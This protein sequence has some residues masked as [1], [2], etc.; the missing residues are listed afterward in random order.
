MTDQARQQAVDKQLTRQGLV[1][2]NADVLSAM[3]HSGEGF[4]F[5]PLRVKTSGEITGEAL[6]SAE[7]LGKLERHTR[8]ILES[9]AQELAAGKIAADPFWEGEDRNAC[10]WCEY[11]A[12]C[13]FREGSGDDHRRWLSGVKAEEFWSRLDSFD[14]QGRV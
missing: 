1:L 14:R 10:K 5:L 8:Q 6:V 12:A 7:R 11:A 13:Q 4:R 3:E 2:D 9:I